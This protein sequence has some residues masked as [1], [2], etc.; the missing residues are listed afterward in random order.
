MANQ[1]A[2]NNE[3]Y[4]PNELEHGSLEWQNATNRPE[5]CQLK[6]FIKQQANKNT[7]TKTASDLRV[8]QRYCD[9][10][11]EK[12]AIETIPVKELDILLGHFFKEVKKVNGHDYEPDTLTG[13]HR[14]ISRYL[15]EKGVNYDIIA[16]REFH[17]SRATLAARRKQLRC[18]GKGQKPNA[19]K[20]ISLDEERALF[21]SGQ[22]GDHSPD[23]LIR[24]VWYFLT[25]HMG[26][27]G[28]D[29]HCKLRYGDFKI[30]TDE[31]GEYVE[32]CFERGTKTRS[33][34][35]AGSLDRAFKP[36]MFA[37]G[38]DYCPVKYFKAYIAHRPAAAN[39]P[40]RPFYLGIK[41]KRLDEDTVWYLNAPMGKNT[42]AKFMKAAS[43]G[44]GI[45]GKKVT[46]HSARKTMV[47]RLVD[48]K[49]TPNVVA[50]LSGHRNLKSLDSY[51]TASD[52][53]QKSM[54]LSLGKS[55][56]TCCQQSTSR[57]TSRPS[58]HGLPGLFSG[59]VLSE[60]TLNIAINYNDS[61]TTIKPPVPKKRC[62]IE[63]DDSD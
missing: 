52:D 55:A 4:Y 12:R 53:T 33:G 48:A 47:Q 37:N 42:I 2:S 13:F 9:E 25:L 51:M 32:W 10:V 28:R 16:D 17:I 50:Q 39:T 34:E 3:F 11:K 56:S 21:D 62:I 46:N 41:D 19:S 30:V 18:N 61:T 29:E 26:M 44:T 20:S 36:K 31:N 7:T 8:L 58:Y 1:E 60:C 59:G 22:F 43:E 6:D 27:R 5:D 63:E 45:S 15:K 23:A 24:T 57:E 35:V 49:F 54:S 40:D 14:S 38:T